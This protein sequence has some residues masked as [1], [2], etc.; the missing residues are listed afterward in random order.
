MRTWRPI[1]GTWHSA[2]SSGPGLRTSQPPWIRELVTGYTAGYNSRLAE[3]VGA[4]ALPTWCADAEW[5]RPIDE[6]DLYAYIGDIALMGS[7]RNLAQL[8]GWAQAPGPDGPF[9]PASAD[10]LKDLH[11]PATAGPSAAM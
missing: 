6:L 2:S 3:L 7:G 8:I 9:P 1:S 10:A 11:R 4:G 5:I